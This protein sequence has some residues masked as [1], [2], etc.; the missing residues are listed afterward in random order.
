MNADCAKKFERL[1]EILKE[2]GSVAI[3]Y[4]GGV[5]STLLVAVAHDV[6]GDNCLAVL[7]TSSTYAR[8]ECEQAIDWIE[9]QDIP[10]T[11]IES[12]ELD[13]P[14]FSDNPPDRCFHCKNE[15]FCKIG[16]VG[17]AKGLKYVAD[18]TNYDD[19]GDYRPGRQA[20]EKLGVLSPL[21]DAE[22]TKQD[23]R[24]V[25]SEVYNLPVA[26]K[27]AMACLASRFPYGQKIT[28]EKLDQT[29]AIEEYLQDQGFRVY[30]ARHHG[31]I[32]RIETSEAEIDK[33]LAPEM[34]KKI[35][36]FSK[37]QGFL[38]VTLDLQGY[39]TGSM[40]EELDL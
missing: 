1:K 11:I 22:M 20:A 21:L 10:F 14:E 2:A 39:R 38:Y 15:L 31:T 24:D 7:S 37:D 32:V 28:R 3:G 19:R 12:E 30:R 26:N 17:Q 40:N 16:E 27:P 36:E 23:I 25:A 34:R 5:D 35:I 13:I 4:S 33:L 8:R 9:K 18:G 6:L 29:Q